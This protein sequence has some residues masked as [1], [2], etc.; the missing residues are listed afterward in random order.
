MSEQTQMDS[1]L[2]ADPAFAPIEPERTVEATERPAPKPIRER[3]AEAAPAREPVRES[4]GAALRR[5]HG[6]LGRVAA[7]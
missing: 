2:G 5:Q 4:A 7:E 3:P 6:A 1:L